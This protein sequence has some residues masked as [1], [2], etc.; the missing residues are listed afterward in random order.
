MVEGLVG[1]LIQEVKKHYTVEPIKLYNKK[2]T[3][4]L[5]F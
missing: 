5:K 2:T 4:R 1:A 3:I